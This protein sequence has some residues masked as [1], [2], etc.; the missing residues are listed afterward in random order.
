M[1]HAVT[2]ELFGY[3]D[4]L[5]AG[6][7]APE[8]AAID[9][10]AIRGVLADTF[11]LDADGA[12]ASLFPFR[13]A[14]TRLNAFWMTELKG[15]SMLTM[16]DVE[17]RNPMLRILQGVL[18]FQHPALAG[19][20]AAPEG[21]APID[22]E[23][24]LLPLRHHGRTHARM[25]GAVAPFEVPSWLGLLAIRHLA[26]R[27]LRFIEEADDDVRPFGGSYRA[28]TR[29]GYLVVHEGGRAIP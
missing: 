10:A 5:R 22:L 20:R 9:P 17:E 3:W 16:F 27:S 26:V 25:L 6:R 14:G 8:R 7:S 4:R 2:R 24:V 12:S 13:L 11:I 28:S 21:Y 29:H 15:R 23:M 1:K 19:L 18:D